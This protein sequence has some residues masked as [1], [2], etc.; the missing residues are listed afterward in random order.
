METCYNPLKSNNAG[1]AYCIDL[2]FE[3]FQTGV[4]N[5]E[6]QIIFQ[7]KVAMF[8]PQSFVTFWLSKKKKKNTEALEY[9][10][11]AIN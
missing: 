2:F 5:L 10:E 4:E 1:L 8:F 6:F 7:R 9:S 3:Y 11:M